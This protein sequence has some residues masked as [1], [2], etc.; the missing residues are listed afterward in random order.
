M[1][2]VQK[3]VQKVMTWKRGKEYKVWPGG[4]QPWENTLLY[5]PM[6]DDLLD[7]SGKWVSVT[8]NWNVQIQN[9]FWYFNGISSLDTWLNSFADKNH[10]INF[11]VKWWNSDTWMVSSNPCWITKWE[12]FYISNWYLSYSSYNGTEQFYRFWTYDSWWHNLV[13]SYWALYYDW[14]LKAT[15]NYSYIW[16]SPFSI[17]WHAINSSCSRRY[18]TWYI[19]RVIIENKVRTA[20]EVSDYYNL[21]KH[22]YWL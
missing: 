4:W 22:F 15:T 21:T 9:S 6:T 11:R 13:F 16:Y 20:Q 1:V 18:W 8:N 19:S 12:V 5:L 7:H 2:L 10:T 17:W 3:E 14:E